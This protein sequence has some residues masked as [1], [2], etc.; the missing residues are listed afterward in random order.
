MLR[1]VAWKF[2]KTLGKMLG[3]FG[4]QIGS[5]SA[6]D[7]AKQDLGPKQQRRKVIVAVY[8]M[9]WTSQGSSTVKDRVY[10]EIRPTGLIE[11]KIPEHTTLVQ[12]CDLIYS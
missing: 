12:W 3:S 6:T 11:P 1:S 4:S 7:I 10:H 9:E 2:S 8:Y 5:Q